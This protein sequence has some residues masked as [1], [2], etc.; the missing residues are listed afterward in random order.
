MYSQE[1][2]HWENPKS[3]L[4]APGPHVDGP[5]HCAPGQNLDAETCPLP[6]LCKLHAPFG[7]GGSSAR[8]SLAQNVTFTFHF[9]CQNCYR[10]PNSS[11]FHRTREA[12]GPTLISYSTGQWIL[13]FPQKSIKLTWPFIRGSTSS[14][15][16]T[17]PHQRYGP[18]TNPHQDKNPNDAHGSSASNMFEIY[19]IPCQFVTNGIYYYFRYYT[20]HS[21]DLLGGN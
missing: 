6:P 19:I 9:P 5:S 2:S 11:T 16:K 18:G 4:R 21:W 10:G 14:A 1:G 12:Q 17:R 7:F 15:D 8:E 20:S 3:S 13:N